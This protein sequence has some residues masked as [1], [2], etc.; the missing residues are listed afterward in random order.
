M[1]ALLVIGLAALLCGC[2]AVAGPNGVVGLRPIVDYCATAQ[3]I[4]VSRAD[5]RATKEQAD[6]EFRKYV[7]ACGQPPA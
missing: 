4:K 5:T 7:A 3:P 2:A 1:K 6:R